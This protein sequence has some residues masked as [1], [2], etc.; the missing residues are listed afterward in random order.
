MSPNSRR[1]GAGSRRGPWLLGALALLA[2]LGVQARDEVRSELHTY[3]AQRLLAPLVG[4]GEVEQPVTL[5]EKQRELVLREIEQWGRN[6]KE[7]TT[8]RERRTIWWSALFGQVAPSLRI[9]A[10]NASSIV[11]SEGAWDYQWPYLTAPSFD[12]PVYDEI[13]AWYLDA[14]AQQVRGLSL[15]ERVAAPTDA[16]S[17]DP[18]PSSAG[19]A[20]PGAGAS[21]LTDD[22]PAPDLFAWAGPVIMEGLATVRAADGGIVVRLPMTGGKAAV[23]YA[24][25]QRHGRPLRLR[26]ENQRPVY[27]DTPLIVVGTTDI[28]VWLVHTSGL[29]P[30][31]LSAFSTGGDSCD[32]SEWMELTVNRAGVRPIW[33]ILGLADASLAEGVTARLLSPGEQPKDYYTSGVQRRD[34][35]LRWTQERLPPCA[36]R[37]DASTGPDASTYANRMGTTSSL[38]SGSSAARGE[39]GCLRRRPHAPA[40][41][42][43][44][45]R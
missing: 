16:P 28:P 12:N 42:T 32:G 35:E 17:H 11:R 36:S 30:A 38:A 13:P 3:W 15:D 41:V 5:P 25:A 31:T 34:L 14:L 24:W 6:A 29:T 20:S 21:W 27:S 19:T 39:P 7:A 10:L 45:R 33:A 4:S 2:P 44:G 22:G 18:S 43:T 40:T 26:L 23:L 1:Y 9:G 37:R 8:S